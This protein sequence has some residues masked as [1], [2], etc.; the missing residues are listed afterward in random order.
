MGCSEDLPTASPTATRS[1]VAP[2]VEWVA[3]PQTLLSG[4][5]V[6]AIA[7]TPRRLLATTVGAAP[8]KLVAVDDAG[9]VQP[10]DP[11]FQ[12]PADLVCPLAISPGFHAGFPEGDVFVGVGR[13][14]WRL[15]PDDDRRE[16]VATLPAAS[17]DIAGLCFDT[18]GDFAHELVVLG[19]AGPVARLG[20]GFAHTAVGNVGSGGRG[21]SIQGTPDG[22]RFI[23]A[24]P[25]AGDVRALA[26]N[27]AVTTLGGWSGVSAALAFPR[28]PRTF[29]R[30][31]AALFVATADGTLL[32]FALS[33]VGPHVG[34][35][36]FTSLHASGS[37]LATPIGTH[38]ELDP[39][40][41]FHGPEVAAAFV[42]RPAVLQVDADVDPDDAG[43]PL[44]RGSTDPVPVA[45]LSAPWFVPNTIDAASV[46]CAGAAAVPSGK[47]GF[48]TFVDV[49]GD[50]VLDLLLAFRPA[51]MDLEL[52]TT[53]VGIDGTTFLEDTFHAEASVQVTEELL[54]PRHLRARRGV[55]AVVR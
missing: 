16:V 42:Q 10:F 39:W 17:G 24:F 53:H 46:R 35:L 21:P 27:G 38:L 55:R 34:S 7:A 45:L 11:A 29:A 18:Q 50:G 52:S 1:K 9:G 40:S 13:D 20:A 32:Q 49:N 12:A 5:P 33:D 43:G 26:P 6:G 15:R 3:R 44:T 28:E 14:L 48:G 4:L 41:R 51:D 8:A 37:G 2:P 47:N 36:L 23:V 25:E 22:A 19:S 54:R 31:G 30:S